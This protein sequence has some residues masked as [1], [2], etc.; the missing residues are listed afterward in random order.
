[1]H[2][3]NRTFDEINVGDRSERVHTVTDSDLVLFASV[4]GD[5]NP[6]HLD[7]E[8]AAST[9][10]KGRIAHGMFTG[11]LISASLGMDLPGPG[12]IYLGQ[13]LSFRKPVMIG[14]TLTVT[15]EV[16]SKHDSKPILTVN[17][18]VTNQNGKVVAAG[19]ASVM[20]P[21]EKMTVTAAELPTINFG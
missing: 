12:T 21:T 20:A 17:C 10:F 4:S 16:A 19:E 14:D 11:A 18:T 5:K 3:T 8:Y 6:V 7:E 15:L 13:S 9:M 1:M 2:I